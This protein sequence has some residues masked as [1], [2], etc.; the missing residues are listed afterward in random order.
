VHGIVLGLIVIRLLNPRPVKRVLLA[1]LFL[2]IFIEG[3]CGTGVTPFEMRALSSFGASRTGF[4]VES[5]FNV[6][7]HAY[8][9][10]VVRQ[11][12]RGSLGSLSCF[13]HDVEASMPLASVVISHYFIDIERAELLKI[14]AASTL[15]AC[16]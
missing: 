2:L 1:S 7:S 5:P 3:L 15:R 14:F 9:Q 10:A 11:L 16:F 4:I 12:G 8:T 13:A 6:G